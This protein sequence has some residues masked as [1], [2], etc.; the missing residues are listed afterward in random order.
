MH[1][2]EP[3]TE[4]SGGNS[5]GGA[6][7][8]ADVDFSVQDAA[9]PEPR[10]R[11]D[12]P[13]EA[14]GEAASSQN[15]AAVV[16]NTG[17]GASVRDVNTGGGAFVGRDLIYNYRLPLAVVAVVLVAALIATSVGGI[18]L[19]DIGRRNLTPCL[20]PQKKPMSGVS[21][22]AI[23]PL[24]APDK[25][26]EETGLYIVDY[27]DRQLQTLRTKTELFDALQ[28]WHNGAAEAT[29]DPPIAPIRDTA[30]AE[31]WRSSLGAS[32]LIFGS[33]LDTPDGTKLQLAFQYG[34]VN[35]AN[36]PDI[37]LG[38]HPF[39]RP[40]S[41]PKADYPQQAKRIL[42]RGE[43]VPLAEY[44]RALL[45]LTEALVRQEATGPRA[46]LAVFEEAEKVLGLGD[47]VSWEVH[48]DVNS[49]MYFYMG[50]TALQVPDFD[51]TQRAFQAVVDHANLIDDKL[52][53]VL[54][55]IG[56]GNLA[57]TRAQTELQRMLA[58]AQRQDEGFCLPTG[59]AAA[60]LPAC[61]D[62]HHIDSEA[63]LQA[64][65]ESSEDAGARVQ[66]QMAAGADY[67]DEA[68]AALHDLDPA[69]D[70][71]VIQETLDVATVMRANLR[72]LQ[73]E[74]QLNGVEE[75]TAQGMEG[76]G[77]QKQL[78]AAQK[79]YTEAAAEFTSVIDAPTN[80]NNV[81]LTWYALYGRGLAQRRA[82]CINE[83]FFGDE[84]DETAALNT[85]AQQS[86]AACGRQEDARAAGK[87]I[88]EFGTAL[89]C[90]CQDAQQ[91]GQTLVSN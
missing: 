53:V 57:Y 35:V 55:T 18:S 25:N 76:E 82:A 64:A 70:N 81:E 56:L 40:V 58:Q 59:T 49:I 90:Q 10:S 48:P 33:L 2:E 22:I 54:A 47:S 69:G 66:A 37:A 79:D 43:N 50:Q 62:I 63:G 6:S 71:A 77:P 83:K 38:H 5:P 68:I 31:C 12:T 4:G 86:F 78:E 60:T 28:I 34:D 67:Y 21:S 87:G 15:Q 36:A 39:A 75:L 74:A 29:L 89:Q 72:R 27:L 9:E 11:A 51:A 19:F 84:G 52:D 91:W 61:F 46:A 88:S 45:F 26:R 32:I 44:A 16:V 8:G 24:A 7:N 17:G 80:K 1:Q 20:V 23:A 73:G 85:G 65:G 14:V 13:A 42:E 41:I 30:D 3:L